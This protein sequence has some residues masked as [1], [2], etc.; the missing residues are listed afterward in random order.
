M[1]AR[2]S[3][4]VFSWSINFFKRNIC[5]IYYCC[6]SLNT[7]LW[8]YVQTQS[9]HGVYVLTR[10]VCV[11]EY[12]Q[13]KYVYINYVWCTYYW[14]NMC[15]AIENTSRGSERLQ[16]VTVSK[17]LSRPEQRTPQVSYLFSGASKIDKKGPA[18]CQ[19]QATLRVRLRPPI[20]ETLI[21]TYTDYNCIR[22]VLRCWAVTNQ[23]GLYMEYIYTVLLLLL[24]N[25]TPP[26]HTPLTPIIRCSRSALID[27]ITS[28]PALCAC[29]HC[30][31]HEARFYSREQYFL[32]SHG[33]KNIVRLRGHVLLCRPRFIF[34]NTLF[35][36]RS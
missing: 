6:Y 18:L 21:N 15:G 17:H 29:A 12:D 28:L 34:G 8:S 24:R 25:P 19:I 32:L 31:Q 13:N 3:I 1:R 11:R 4:Q 7:V 35:Q 9:P 26:P 5:H 10:G 30:C 16:N 27:P 14:L 33:R 20:V 2:H 22:H 36:P 23:I